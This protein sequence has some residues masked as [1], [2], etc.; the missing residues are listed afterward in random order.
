MQGSVPLPRQLRDGRMPG[1]ALLHC[2]LG[3]EGRTVTAPT[4][5][6]TR[7]CVSPLC[8]ED[9]RLRGRGPGQATAEPV[10][11]TLLEAP[12]FPQ[13]FPHI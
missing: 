1:L 9:R 12:G 13:Q 7:H 10:C 8:V 3:E 5:R 4:R 2:D 6:L 11:L